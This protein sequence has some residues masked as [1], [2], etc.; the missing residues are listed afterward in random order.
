M[1]MGEQLSE[2][3]AAY[4]KAIGLLSPLVESAPPGWKRDLAV[5]YA[6]RGE[7]R[8]LAGKISGAHSDMRAALEL[9]TTLRTLE[10]D[11]VQLKEDE[12]W[13]KAHLE[14]K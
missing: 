14:T 9:I 7:A 6:E 11:D 2:I 12:K 1:N 4:A 3:D 10:P 5:A 8:R 13:L